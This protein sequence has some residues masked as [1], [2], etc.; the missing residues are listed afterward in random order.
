[1]PSSATKKGITTIKW[2]TDAVLTEAAYTAAIVAR[3]TAT[4]K[5]GDPIEIEGNQGFA[6]A[7]VILNDGFNA[8]ME[9]LYDSAIEWPAEGD[10][11][12]I[13]RPL[14]EAPIACLLTSI[15]QV[16]ERKKEATLTLKLLY[17]PD[18]SLA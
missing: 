3:M 11:V 4:P 13:Q 9:V 6:A 12:E 2:G 1:M 17:R 15:E 8:T 7:L 14:D 10:T 16:T 18:V 5:N